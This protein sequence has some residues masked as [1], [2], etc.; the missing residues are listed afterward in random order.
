MFLPE[1]VALWLLR[2]WGRFRRS[3]SSSWCNQMRLL[4]RVYLLEFRRSLAGKF[5]KLSVTKEGHSA[6]V[7]FPAGWNEKGWHKIFSAIEDIVGQFSVDSNLGK[8]G[9]GRQMLMTKRGDVGVPPPPPPP[10]GC[11]LQCGLEVNQLVS[12]GLMLVLCLLC[13]LIRMQG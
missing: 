3:K 6:F 13:L 7:I 10:L 5:L 4:S 2:A 1:P 8:E 9:N 11:C 12:F